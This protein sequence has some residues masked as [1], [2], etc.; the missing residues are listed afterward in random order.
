M[1]CNLDNSL[2]VFLGDDPQQNGVNLL[3]P[4]SDSVFNALSNG[5]IHFAL[6]GSSLN[7][8]LIGCN[9]CNSQSESF[10]LVVLKAAMERKKKGT[11]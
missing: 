5:T 4:V 9:N 1:D 7:H 8:N 10:V 11:I 3:T 2:F 6:Y